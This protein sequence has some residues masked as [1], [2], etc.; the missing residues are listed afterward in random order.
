[1]QVFMKTKDMIVGVIM[2]D[3]ELGSKIRANFSF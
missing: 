3:T 1:M 2:E